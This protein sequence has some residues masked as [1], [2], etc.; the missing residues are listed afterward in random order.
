MIAARLLAASCV[1]AL[2]LVLHHPLAE[3][4]F[5]VA[6]PLQQALL[7]PM[8]GDVLA[9]RSLAR[10]QAAPAGAPPR[11]RVDAE[12]IGGIVGTARLPDGL[13]FWSSV[14]QG[15]MLV[16]LL[17]TVL[18]LFAFQL[19]PRCS[20]P[21]FTAAAV[22]G[23]GIAVADASVML[24][25]ALLLSLAAEAPGAGLSGS[26]AVA[27]MRASGG[28]AMVALGAALGTAM[29]AWARQA[30]APSAVTKAKPTRAVVGA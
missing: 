4:L 17:A 14:P 5:R 20:V 11:L 21:A 18:P 25:G 15:R 23:V 9:V 13:Q 22:A 16:H 24:A 29:G 12:S 30:Q 3:G 7:P 26:W 10:D 19:R 6:L 2:A 8:V 1:L 27:A 28:G